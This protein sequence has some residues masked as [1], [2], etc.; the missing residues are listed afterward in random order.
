MYS[1]PSFVVVHAV[2]SIRTMGFSAVYF[3]KLSSSFVIIL[4][5]PTIQMSII[6]LTSKQIVEKSFI[7]RLPTV[8]IIY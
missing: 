1:F 8:T 7:G 4:R 2:V 5:G 6:S 3:S